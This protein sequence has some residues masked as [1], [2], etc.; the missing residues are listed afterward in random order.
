MRA[1]E[2]RRRVAAAHRAAEGPHVVRRTGR[3]GRPRG[4]GR[5]PWIAWFAAQARV[6]P[7]TV[8]RWA[9][10]IN[11]PHPS[12]IAVLERIEEDTNKEGA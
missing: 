10:G 12:A 9:K 5:W 1:T 8:W 4:T 7:V 2:F 3:K 11:P 6:T